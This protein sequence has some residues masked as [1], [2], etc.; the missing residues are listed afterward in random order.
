MALETELCVT[1]GKNVRVNVGLHCKVCKCYKHRKCEKV[2]SGAPI[3]DYMCKKCHKEKEAEMERNSEVTS[4]E[5]DKSTSDSDISDGE[6]ESDEARKC[7]ICQEVVEENCK[8]KEENKSLKEIIAV[9]KKDLEELRKA[10]SECQ[11]TQSEWAEVVRGRRADKR[12]SNVIELR[13][14]FE[15]LN[16]HVEDSGEKGDGSV[17]GKTVEKQCDKKKKKRVLLLASSHGRHCGGILQ[18]K[19]GDQY[20]VCGVVKPNA[21]FKNVVESVE[22]LTKDF[23]KDD[24]VIVMA[25]GND[26]EDVHFHDSFK[27]GIGKVMAVKERT[28]VIINALPPRYDNSDLKEKVQLMNKFL[29]IE[30]NRQGKWQ[31]QNVRM[32]FEMER[33]DRKY[34][35]RH[36]LHLNFYGKNAVCEK[37][38]ALV[39]DF[40]KKENCQRCAFLGH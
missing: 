30:V 39:K 5:E 33:M 11:T 38:C 13:N 23:G 36:G 40:D 26:E 16:R 7:G 3:E 24:C 21:K 25:G 27:E 22:G 9:L 19:L 6:T 17:S 29:H 15:G 10:G 8:L 1:C 35:T 4:D 37:M 18:N 28:N 20:N 32:N 34:F 2:E 14:R 31:N 12:R